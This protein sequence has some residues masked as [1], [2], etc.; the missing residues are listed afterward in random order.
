M[1]SLK[2]WKRISWMCENVQACTLVRL[3]H[4]HVYNT[5]Y[6]SPKRIHCWHELWKVK[7]DSTIC[8]VV[9]LSS[10]RLNVTT[11]QSQ[12]ITQVR[13]VWL[14]VTID[15][16][17]SITQVT[18][19]WLNMTVVWWC[20]MHLMT[21]V[22][23]ISSCHYT[24]KTQL[25]GEDGVKLLVGLVWIMATSWCTVSELVMNILKDGWMARVYSTTLTTSSHPVLMSLD[26]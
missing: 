26:H 5:S 17:Q 19:V 2:R 18:V 24:E 10:V 14:N 16:S 20:V 8:T 1:K 7:T 9:W 23:N 21:A 22:S 15:Q 4:L 12:S 11:D 25:P 13:V 3:V 6:I